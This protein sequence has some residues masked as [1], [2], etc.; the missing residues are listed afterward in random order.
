[1]CKHVLTY[2]SN[3]SIWLPMRPRNLWSL[4]M[5][6]WLNAKEPCCHSNTEAVGC[7]DTCETH[8]FRLMTRGTTGMSGGCTT[9]TQVRSDPQLSMLLGLS[10]KSKMQYI[11]TQLNIKTKNRSVNISVNTV[12]F[13]GITK[14]P[15]TVSSKIACC[16]ELKE[17]DCS[18]SAGNFLPY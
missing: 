14:Q 11:H 9:S 15:F 3:V 10:I 18:P 16:P 5:C 8:L 1:M 4:F 17:I 13:T 2:L 6:N 12:F 7:C